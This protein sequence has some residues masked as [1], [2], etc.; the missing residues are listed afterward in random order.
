M[1]SFG[2]L[3]N[4]PT[5]LVIFS[6]SVFANSSL[7]WHPPWPSYTPNT[8]TRLHFDRTTFHRSSMYCRSPFTEEQSNTHANCLP[9]I[10]FL[11]PKIIAFDDDNDALLFVVTSA[12]SS[13]L[14]LSS[15]LL[16]KSSKATILLASGVM[17]SPPAFLFSSSSSS[18]SRR[19]RNFPL[20]SA[21]SAHFTP[22][23]DET[24]EKSSS[25]VSCASFSTSFFSFSSF[26]SRKRSVLLSSS[27]ITRR[28]ASKIGVKNGT[29]L[30]V[31][32][33]IALYRDSLY[34]CSYYAWSNT[35]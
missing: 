23:N 22:E 13:L 4:R 15:P 20:I 35:K 7:T 24:F 28:S 14:L 17:V 2:F 18:S 5:S 30:V 3:F 9:F 34:N 6:P 29:R 32:I 25:R 19:R 27:I 1:V 11:F 33:V 16:H 21:F 10:C 12:L 31:D 26:L 8:A